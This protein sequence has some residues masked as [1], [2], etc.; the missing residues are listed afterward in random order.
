MH[1]LCWVR[2]EG[3]LTE[4]YVLDAK[5]ADCWG[6]SQVRRIANNEQYSSRRQVF[7]FWYLARV[8]SCY[9]TVSVALCKKHRRLQYTIL[10]GT[11]FI[12]LFL[13]VVWVSLKTVVLDWHNHI[14][15]LD[16]MGFILFSR[17]CILGFWKFSSLKSDPRI[18]QIT[19]YA[20]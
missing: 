11:N 2:L 14:N 9:S 18:A 20:L 15:W 6:K 12:R 19:C 3:G 17:K 1:A 16:G 7:K 13:N 8:V 5:K 4:N 10:V